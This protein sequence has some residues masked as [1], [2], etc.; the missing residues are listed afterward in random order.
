MYVLTL[1]N[2]GMEIRRRYYISLSLFALLTIVLRKDGRCASSK[3]TLLAFVPCY[4]QAGAALR[5][6]DGDQCDVLTYAAAQLAADHTNRDSAS[7]GT[8]HWN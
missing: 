4:D 1:F 6:K 5:T 2:S 3:F 8:L 7:S